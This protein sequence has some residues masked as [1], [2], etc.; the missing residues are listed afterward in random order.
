MGQCSRWQEPDSR[1]TLVVI[2]GLAT[3]SKSIAH[4]PFD[5]FT[6]KM[7]LQQY[8]CKRAIVRREL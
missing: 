4:S 3:W 7:G 8:Q 2:C 1:V 5:F 6:R